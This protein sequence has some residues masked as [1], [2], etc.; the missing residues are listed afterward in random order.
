MDTSRNQY[1]P[2][3]VF[4][5][6]ETLAEKLEEMGMSPKKFALQSR[7]PE[8]VVLSILKCVIGVTPDMAERFEKVLKIPAHFWM[9]KQR[10]FDEWVRNSPI[11]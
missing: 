6:G 2:Q 3:I 11:N 8:K 10:S 1:H 4:H 5:P 9:N 7:V